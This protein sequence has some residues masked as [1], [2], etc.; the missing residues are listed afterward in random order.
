MGKILTGNKNVIPEMLLQNDNTAFFSQFLK[1]QGRKEFKGH[2]FQSAKVHLYNLCNIFSL[3]FNASIKAIFS[4]FI[5]FWLFKR[6]PL[7][8]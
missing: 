1:F 3:S 5:P 8:N 4:T 6:I 7:L 2:K